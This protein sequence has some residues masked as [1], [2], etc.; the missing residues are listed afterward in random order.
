MV[1]LNKASEMYSHSKTQLEKFEKDKALEKFIILFNR[2]TNLAA[3]NG[4]FGVY[5]PK[6][7][8]SSKY[9]KE[10]L[11]MLEE[12]G[13]DVRTSPILSSYLVSWNNAE[14]DDE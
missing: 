6:E 5:I 8:I 11:T 7:N 13:Y 1:S 2:E 14:E 12:N 3:Q 10:I 9:R 4:E